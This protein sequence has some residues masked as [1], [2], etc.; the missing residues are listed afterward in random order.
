MAW[1]NICIPDTGVEMRPMPKNKLDKYLDFWNATPLPRARQA[2][3]DLAGS[4]T[5][6]KGR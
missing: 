1:F 2:R 3:S 6:S 4:T 5:C